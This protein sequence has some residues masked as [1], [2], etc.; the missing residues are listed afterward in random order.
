MLD[1]AVQKAALLLSGLKKV[2]SRRR[3]GALNRTIMINGKDYMSRMLVPVKYAKTLI[4]KRQI[5]K[6][7]HK[8]GN[9]CNL[10]GIIFLEI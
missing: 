5:V 10:F 2:P 4:E 6:P 7:L 9:V 8:A 1:I 3:S